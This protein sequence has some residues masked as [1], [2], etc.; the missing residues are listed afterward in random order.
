MG[1]RVSSRARKAGTGLPRAV[2]VRPSTARPYESNPKSVAGTFHHDR[3]LG[4]RQSEE[5]G[6][7]C[8]ANE[9]IRAEVAGL[10]V[11]LSRGGLPREELV[12][13]F[14][15]LTADGQLK[16]AFSNARADTPLADL[17]RAATLCWPIEQCF[18]DGKSQVGMDHYEHRSW[19]AW[20]RHMLH[21][22][23]A[24]HFLLR[25]RLRFKRNAGLDAP[26]SA[27]ARDN[28]AAVQS[29][30]ARGCAVSRALPY[31]AESHCV[32]LAPEEA[33]GAAS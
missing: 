19:L 30:D 7:G 31:E 4:G 12:W 14:L 29:L 28:G 25:L 9:P 3:R 1:G 21:V 22:F 27:N 8:W 16:Y 24:L 5:E 33:A 15:R 13:L 2:C 6:A 32:S 18:Q 26:A 23:L 20:H 10:R 11:Y 17:C